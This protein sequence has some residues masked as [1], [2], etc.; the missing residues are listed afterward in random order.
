MYDAVQWDIIFFIAGVI[1]LGLAMEHTGA[2]VLIAEML[3]KSAAVL[4]PIAV[5]GLFYVVTAILT[6]IIS[7]QASVVLMAPVAFE[8][9]VRIGSVPISFILAVMF[10]GSTAFMTPIGYQTNLLVYGPG[11]Y[12]FSDYVRV[13]A[14]LQLL[15]AVVTTAC[16][17]VFWGV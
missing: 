9:A 16:I 5:L 8:S 13:G 12:R 11:G 6:N 2:A 15:F 3:A 17:A 4:P 1:P 14:P 10:A 7:N